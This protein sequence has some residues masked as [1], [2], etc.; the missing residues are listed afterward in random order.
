MLSEGWDVKSVTHII[1]LRAFGIPFVGF[2]VEKRKRPRIHRGSQKVWIEK[3][4]KKEKHRLRVP[5]VRSWAVGVKS[6]LVQS[7]SVDELPEL[8]IDPR[9][10]PPR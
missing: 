6:S 5:N 8:I 7:M 2:P 3:D 9:Q 1:G 4:D 10:T